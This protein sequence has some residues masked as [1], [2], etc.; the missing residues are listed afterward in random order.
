MNDKKFIALSSI[1]FLMFIFGMGT[2]FV[3]EPISNYL[4]AT[5]AQVSSEKSFI[6]AIPQIGKTEGSISETKPA[7]IKV[8]VYIR[9]DSGD[10]LAQKTVKLSTDL[11]SVNISP[12][13]TQDTNKDGKAEFI[14]TSTTP[15]VAQ[16]TAQELTSG[17]TISNSLSVEFT[18]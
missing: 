14:L 18:P 5:T 1:F 15:G 12:S 8:N 6:T 9:T 17:K 16:L 11:T 3:Q 7:Q 10:L 4:R 13:D 2:L